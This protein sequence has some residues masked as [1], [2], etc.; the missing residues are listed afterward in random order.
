[1]AFQHLLSPGV[2]QWAKAI[3]K[4]SIV[5]VV[6]AGLHPKKALVEIVA[7]SPLKR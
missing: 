2:Q 5:K 1:M 6:S 3:K 4:C 7:A